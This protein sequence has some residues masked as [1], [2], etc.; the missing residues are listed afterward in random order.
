MMQRFWK[1]P[2]P[3]TMSLGCKGYV[4][5]ALATVTFEECCNYQVSP[6]QAA[7]EAW[8]VLGVS[9]ERSA[10]SWGLVKLMEPKS[11]RCP[12]SSSTRHSQGSLGVRKWPFKKKTFQLF[13]TAATM[14]LRRNSIAEIPHRTSPSAFGNAML[15]KHESYD[16][17]ASWGSYRRYD[18]HAHRLIGGHVMWSS[19]VPT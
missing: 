14:S 6:T 9:M 2:V 19:V 11:F 4:E 8:P 13:F 3:N 1:L 7:S 15:C 12:R 5:V 16:H 17:M 18:Q 10:C